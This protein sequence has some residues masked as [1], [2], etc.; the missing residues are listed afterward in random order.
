M[1]A[2]WSL[3]GVLKAILAIVLYLVITL[4]MF[5]LFYFLVEKKIIPYRMAGDI[6]VVLPPVICGIASLPLSYL[7]I[8]GRFL[9][10]AIGPLL[11]MVIGITTGY[12]TSILTW[13]IMFAAIVL[14]EGI[15]FIIGYKSKWS[16]RVCAPIASSVPFLSMIGLYFTFDTYITNCPLLRFLQD[17]RII[18]SVSQ[19]LKY[20]STIPLFISIGVAVLF[21]SAFGNYLMEC[22]I[23][24]SKIE[25]KKDI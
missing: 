9:S 14:A 24:K 10:S 16:Y 3:K 4:G 13:I 12:I 19:E 8:K 20:H 5:Y 1:F 2:K 23:N 21:A 15:R 18:S 22:F 17:E 6:Y 25:A 11:F 7:I